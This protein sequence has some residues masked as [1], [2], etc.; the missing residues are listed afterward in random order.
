[1]FSRI[2]LIIIFILSLPVNSWAA[3]SSIP[4]QVE[5]LYPANQVPSTKGYFDVDVHP[6]E[7]VI[8][9]VKLK[10]SEEKSI[11]VRVKKANAYTSPTGGIFYEVDIDTE[12]SML[13]DDAVRMNNFVETEKTITIPAGESLEVPIQVTVPDSDGSTLLGGILFTQIPEQKEEE[14]QETAKNEAKFIVNTETTYAI[15]VK[16][17]LPTKSEPNFSLGEAGFKSSTAQAFIEMTN[18]AHLIQDKIEGS[19]AVIDNEGNELFNGVMAEFKMAPKTK[20]RFPFDWDHETLEDG[21]YTLVIN[22]QAGEKEFTA[23]ETFTISNKQVQEYAEKT[24]PT[25]D[26]QKEIPMWVWIIGAILFGIV[27]FF[28]GRRKKPKAE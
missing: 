4:M 20:I 2:V 19:Y 6:R 11:T 3:E 23:K 21:M 7:Q 28:L 5:L 15:A 12:D 22:G 13:L 25:V 1:M 16:L 27:M 9:Y 24:K 10:N 14:V 26:V 8:L 18:D 17:N